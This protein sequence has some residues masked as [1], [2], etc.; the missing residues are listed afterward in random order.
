MTYLS[1]DGRHCYI[2]TTNKQLRE[3]LISASHEWDDES[4]IQVS[5]F[6]GDE[7]TTAVVSPELVE[8]CFKRKDND[9]ER[10]EGNHN[11]H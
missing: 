2:T 7:L 10:R 6:T 11:Q 9:A 8:I 1:C 3:K 5:P 4:K